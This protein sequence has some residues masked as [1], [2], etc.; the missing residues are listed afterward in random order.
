MMARSTG[1]PF[2][3]RIQNR[4]ILSLQYSFRFPTPGRSIQRR[5]RHGTDSCWRAVAFCEATTKH[6]R[7]RARPQTFASGFN[8]A[9]NGDWHRKLLSRPWRVG[10]RLVAE[11]S[12]K[13][14]S[15]D[16]MVRP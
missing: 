14:Y 9:W 16:R 1:G 15:L 11:A 10:V 8:F 12:P 6:Q 4:K 13:R 5:I 3:G 2:K 7:V